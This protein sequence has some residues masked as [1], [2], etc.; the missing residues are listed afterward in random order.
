MRSTKVIVCIGCGGVGKTTVSAALGYAL[1]S[2]GFKVLVLTIDPSQRLASTLGIEGK[3]NITQVLN[4]EGK[5]QLFASVIDHALVFE[6]FIKRASGHGVDVEPI[7]KN[8]LYQQMSTNLSGSQ[9][10]TALEMLYS[11]YE[12]NDFDWIILDTPPAKHAIDFLNAPQKLAA[13]FN[14]SLAKWIKIDDQKSSWFSQLLAT[15]TRQI[16]QILETLTGSEF[17]KEL[18]QFFTYVNDWQKKLEDRIIQAHALLVGPQTKFFLITGLDHA[19]L[20]EAKEL[21]SLI[22]RQGY[23]LENVI[24]NR[25]YPEKDIKI[26][27][28]STIKN[29]DFNLEYYNQWKNRYVEWTNQRSNLLHKYTDQW[30]PNF[31]VI[32]L[33]D[34]FHTISDKESLKLIA[35]EVLEKIKL[36]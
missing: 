15:S 27:E 36:E 14:E 33:K 19:K 11:S 7:L 4:F 32:A 13:L 28:I 25:A 20:S 6:N 17:V 16:I 12:S 10:F 9:E 26:N 35:S 1:A 3:K 23:R 18:R 8:R 30:K 5:G 34:Y 29:E 21:G 31:E 2:K 22:D 24:I